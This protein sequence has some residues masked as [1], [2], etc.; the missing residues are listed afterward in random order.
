[1]IVWPVSSSVWTR[2]VGS[3]SDSFCRRVAELVGVDLGLGLDRDVDHGG[4]EVHLLEQHR[5][6][7]VA[8]RVARQRVLE[9]DDRDDVAGEDRVLVLAVV[10]VHLEDAADAL[11]A[12]ACRVDHVV[13][14]L[15]RSR[16]DAH[17]GEAA[18]VGVAH[19]LEREGRERLVVVGLAHRPTSPRRGVI[20]LVRR[21]VQRARQVPADRVEQRLHGLVLERG[22]AQDRV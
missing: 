15:E 12:V 7:R 20:A 22:A 19:D 2:N 17:V 3:S 1:M 8:E 6:T 16:V 13:A 18:D 10:G 4:R 9:T 21:Q 14:A 5:V 11:L